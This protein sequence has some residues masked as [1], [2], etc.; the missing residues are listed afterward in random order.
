MNPSQRLVVNTAATYGRS[1]FAMVLALFSCRWVLN[2]LGQTDFGLFSVVGSTI[3]F[4]SFLNQV[5]ANSVSRHLAYS[6]GSG[7]S[8]E[9]NRWFNAALSIHVCFASV[10]IMI[11][12][13]IGEY[14]V[15]HILTIPADRMHAC[16]WT[17]RVSLISAFVSMVSVPFVG[18]FT[19]KQHISEMAVWG[20]LQ[21]SL[22]FV[23]AL[24]LSRFSGDLLCVYAIGMGAIIVLIQVI[25]ASRALRVFPECRL[26]F[27][28]WCD[29]HRFKEIT[30][31]AF[32]NLIGSFG[33]TCRDEGTA[34][35]LNLYFGS[36]ENAAYGIAKQVSGQTN[37]LASA[38]LGA[39]S[40]EITASEGRGDRK[41]MLFLTDL[42]N[43]FGTILV[44][45]FAVPLMVE[46]EYILVIWLE[47]PPPS[48]AM[49]CRLI[50]VTF[51]LDR[52]S[53]GYLLAVN[54][55]G[56]IVGYQ[57]TIGGTV[58]MTLPLAWLFLAM[59]ASA[60]SVGFAFIITMTIISIGRLFWARRLFGVSISR[61]SRA[62]VL[63]S[64]II[65]LTALFGALAVQW[66]MPASFLRLLCVVAASTT[67]S[68]LMM[69]FFA[70][71]S[72]ERVFAYDHGQR[73]LERLGYA[74]MK[75]KA[76]YCGRCNS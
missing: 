22:M 58:L 53:N 63:P 31:F 45:L 48:T 16:V 74:K 47:T 50:L 42:A 8:E 39:F 19:A 5:L 54:A 32:W 20:I 17:F 40:P 15:T 73:L 26:V 14:A 70:L 1:V 7:N 10:L 51:I 68:V 61:W 13:P 25:L 4:I 33:S 44:L 56:R 9:S 60:S 52:L 55:Y 21:S 23:L 29:S 36:R 67:A 27:Q 37:Q 43:K 66:L 2:A 62:V 12:W 30:H 65:G 34:I 72:G 41:R 38:M 18:M 69:W 76:D 6:I 28:Q 35:L 71:T 75:K 59:G 46:M 64:S 24:F 11:G 3:V 49:F 57:A